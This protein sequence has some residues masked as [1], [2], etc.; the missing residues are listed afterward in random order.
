MFAFAAMCLIPAPPEKPRDRRQRQAAART[1]RAAAVLPGVAAA[2]I[3]MAVAAA[4][5]GRT[6]F[7]SMVTERGYMPCPEPQEYERRPPLRW[8]LPGGRCP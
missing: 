2:G 6:I 7:S 3:V 8:H 4:P 5:I 1:W